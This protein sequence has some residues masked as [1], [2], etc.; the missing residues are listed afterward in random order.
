MMQ[1][2]VNTSVSMRI[3]L[4]VDLAW[5]GVACGRA[6]ARAS[7]AGDSCAMVCSGAISTSDKCE[8]SHHHH[9]T[10]S[11]VYGRCDR[12][13][14]WRQ[15]WCPHTLRR[16]GETRQGTG[17]DNDVVTAPGGP[18]LCSGLQ[19]LVDHNRARRMMLHE[20]LVLHCTSTHTPVRCHMLT[21]L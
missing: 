2:H 18:Q 14:C 16:Q 12:Q 11:T 9:D 10:G 13:R 17:T 5:H 15:R 8:S 6:G 21:K 19:T 3:L 7:K 4:I 20:R 1:A